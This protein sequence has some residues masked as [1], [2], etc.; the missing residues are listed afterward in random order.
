MQ[1]EA[2]WK[3]RVLHASSE[4]YP[5]VS[6]GGLSS[7]A[8]DLPRA[9]KQFAGIDTAVVLPCYGGVAEKCGSVEWQ[10]P[11][12]TFLS[13]EFG[14]GLTRVQGLQVILVAKDEYFGRYGIY[15]ENSGHSWPDNPER[16]S[17]FSRAVSRIASGYFEPDV[18]HCHDWQTSLVPVYLRNKPVPTVL[19]IHNLQFQGRFG[20]ESWRSSG[21]PDSLY[22]INGLEFFGDWNCLKGG[23]IFADRVTTVSPGYAKEILTPEYGCS[24]QG[25]LRE[26]SRKLTGIL[27]GIDTGLWNPSSDPALPAVY[28]PGEMKGKSICKRFL[29]EETG[30]QP[31]SEGLLLGMVSRL[32]GQKG[33]DLVIK[34]ADQIAESGSRLVVLGTGETWA[35]E[36][37]TGITQ[38][39]PGKI[40]SVIAYDDRLARLVFAG[41]DGFLMPSRFE[42]C[43]LGQMMAMR[44]GS[45]PLVRS[46]GGLTDTVNEKR[47][48][49]FTGGLKEFLR[50]LGEME[51]AWEDRRQWSWYRRRCMASDFSWAKSV[52][53]YEE[54]Y[55]K[56]LENR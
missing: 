17:F 33:I 18:V 51:K 8:A 46:V 35:E 48:F 47:G 14:I 16:F 31:D 29:E 30:L 15:G 53:E 4:L 10:P 32:T 24:L 34:A 3:M 9:L 19:T 27:N 40:S 2:E 23:I 37:L 21:L 22:S 49:S 42:P 1:T 41:S 44:Y 28:R 39:H 26:H 38:S 56:A 7:V 25:V 36:A 43:G 5:L 6:T 50:T 13:E 52:K 55:G 12:S 11:E 54:V 20:K 45:V